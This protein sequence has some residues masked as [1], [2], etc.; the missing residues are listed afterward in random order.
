MIGH[1]DL[2]EEL[3]MAPPSRKL[4]RRI[5]D[6]ARPY[7]RLFTQ[8]LALELLFV[9]ARVAGPHIVKRAIDHGIP[10]K[11]FAELMICTA[12]LVTLHAACWLFDFVQ[13][14]INMVA[15]QRI[16]NDLRRSVFRHVQF[17]SMSYFDKTKAGKIISRIDRDVAAM[18]H[19][20]VWGPITLINGTFYMLLSGASMAFYSWKLSLVIVGLV[21]LILIASEA[22]RRKGI[23]AYRQ[24]RESLAVLTA[25]VA[26]SIAGIRV[27]QAFARETKNLLFYSNLADR[28]AMNVRNAAI[29]WNLYS[30]FVRTLYVIATA[31]IVLYGGYLVSEGE[32]EVGVLAAFVLYLGMFFGPIFEFSALFN[33]I[34]HGSSAA[35]RVFQVL[36]TEPQVKDRPGAQELP[37]IEGR[38]EFQAVSFRYAKL[39]AGRRAPWTIDQVSFEANPGELIAFVGKTGAGKSTII[40]LLSRFYEPESGRVL[41]DGR[42]IAEHTLESLHRQMGIVLQENFLFSGTVLEN[43]RY[44]RPDAT[45]EEIEEL[46]RLLGADEVIR[47]LPQGYDSVVGE[48]GTSLSQGERQLICFVRAIVPDPRILILDE[49]TSSVDSLS[50]E[51]LQQ[52]LLRLVKGRTSFVVAHRLSTVRHADR[53]F[54]LDGGRIVES[55]TH[56]QLLAAG[57]QYAKLHTEYVRP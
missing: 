53:I 42:D 16:L 47:R 39:G 40:H 22:F 46:S 32:V 51:R 7:R 26:E 8:M 44:S 48:R 9:L 14:R 54:V 34:L 49:A 13:F 37:R 56:V 45:R 30:P 43:L 12:V 27:T 57:G 18:E 23:V 38:V 28:H 2:E 25:N 29:V 35:E 41:V 50:E 1:V 21:P 24:C 55:G 4:A 31:L 10:E 11:A 52:A 3:A 20:L 19:P 6:L 17:L 36:E 15:G 5:L 33:E